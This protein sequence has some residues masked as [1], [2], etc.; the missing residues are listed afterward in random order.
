MA[1]LPAVLERDFQ[2][3]VIELAQRTGWRVAHF[4][5]AR[6]KDPKTGEETWRTAVQGDG[7]GFPDLVMLR[8]PRLLVVELKT[9]TGKVSVDQAAWLH[10]F[11]DADVT[12]RVWRP[13][14][15]PAIEAALARHPRP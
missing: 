3:Q 14:D 6:A 13:S 12:T 1:R 11:G 5:P 10:A 8:G 15:W 2:D 7:K 9:D 4:R